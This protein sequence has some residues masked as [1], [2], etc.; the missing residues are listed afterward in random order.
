MKNK[1]VAISSG[2]GHLTELRLISSH[3]PFEITIITETQAYLRN[4]GSDPRV[5]YGILDPHNSLWRYILNSAQSAIIFF[6]LRPNIIISTGSGIALPFLV[7][8]KIFGRKIIFVETG[9]RVIN[10]SR[11]GM[12]VYKIADKFYIQSKELQKFYPNAIVLSLFEGY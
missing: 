5:K 3:I 1:I 6:K 12:F 8:G 7:I 9:A 10:P 11:T 2:G 4:T